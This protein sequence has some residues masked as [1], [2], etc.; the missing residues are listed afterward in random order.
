MND[1]FAT[2]AYKEFEKK[3][4][5]R[6]VKSFIDNLPLLPRQ[7]WYKSHRTLQKIHQELIPFGYY[8]KYDKQVGESALFYLNKK[9][10]E[11][12][13]YLLEGE[14]KE[15]VQIVSAFYEEDEAIGDRLL[16]GGINVAEAVWEGDWLAQLQERL[17]E[18][19]HKKHRKN[20]M[21]VDILLVAQKNH[22][23]WNAKRAYPDIMKTLDELAHRTQAKSSFRK[24]V[25]VDS[26]LVGNGDIYVFP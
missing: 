6:E 1:P 12:D 9:D 5:E 17:K 8:V 13:G 25:I 23:I 21:P 7:I 20:Y 24:I 3:S 18:R 11:A 2:F 4:W 16:M 22:F 14:K 26:D 19:V 10:D 15:S